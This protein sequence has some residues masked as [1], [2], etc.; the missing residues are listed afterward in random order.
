MKKSLLLLLLAMC[1]SAVAQD[2]DFEVNKIAFKM[3]KIQGGSFRMGATNEQLSEAESDEFPVQRITVNDF[4][5]GETEVTQELWEAVMGKNPSFFVGNT[6]RPVENVSWLDCQIF[7]KRLNELTHKSGQLPANLSFALPTEAQWE[8]AC[9][10]GTTSAY[11]NGG[12]TEADL[13]KLGRYRGTGRGLAAVGTYQPNAWGL[14]DMHGNVWEW[15][16]DWYQEDATSLK[17]FTDPKGAASG[18]DRVRR[19]GSWFNTVGF[20]RS[21]YRGSNAPSYEGADRG[22]R[23]SRTLP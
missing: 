17:Q 22:F 11:N 19:G 5:L 18:S 16:R 15:C 6:K 12:D 2:L 3:I 21:A 4:Y 7:I 20:C 1:C 10:A 23:L 14:Y 13:Q 8:Y 9:R